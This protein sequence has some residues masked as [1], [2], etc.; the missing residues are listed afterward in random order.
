MPSLLQQLA[1]GKESWKTFKVFDYMRIAILTGFLLISFLGY[2]RNIDSIILHNQY[3][4]RL[5]ETSV[6]INGQHF[7]T[8]KN[9]VIYSVPVNG[10][11][12]IINTEGYSEERIELRKLPITGKIEVIKNF[13]WK[14]L[15]NPEFYIYHGGLWLILI[16]VF[17]E[18][19]LFVGFFFPGDALLFVT[20]ILSNK[21]VTGALF[22]THSTLLD[23]LILWTLIGTA[24]IL[25]NIVGYWFGNKSGHFLY[26]RKDTW[27]FKKKYL[28]QAHDFYEKNGGK[29]IILARFLPFVRTFAP[30]VAGVVEMNKK[31]FIYFNI[32][33]A[34]LWVG[35]MLIGGLFLQKWIK[36][37]F[38]FD[39]KD[40]LE[41]IVIGIIAI[42]TLPVIWKVFFDKKKTNKPA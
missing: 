2:S 38:D 30:I 35:S 26:S 36:H 37:Q 13:T 20:G 8:D 29:A 33:G 25:G 1:S 12:L 31:K 32:I 7:T 14:D 27:L 6:N 40:H 3:H 24:A 22:A 11:S 23:L 34:I 39:L 18:T 21:I 17:A 4:H 5:I 15:L 42:T 28:L 10:D 16:I 19:G 9:G 41:V